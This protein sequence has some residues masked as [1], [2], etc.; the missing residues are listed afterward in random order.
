MDKVHPYEEPVKPP[1]LCAFKFNASHFAAT[2]DVY[3]LFISAIEHFGIF[4]YDDPGRARRIA[5]NPEDF[6][7]KVINRL[8]FY[9]FYNFHNFTIF[10][11]FSF[12][13]FH[14]LHS[15]F[16]FPLLYDLNVA[17]KLSSDLKKTL[18]FVDS[19][20][21]YKTGNEIIVIVLRRIHDEAFLS[22]AGNEPY[23]VTEVNEEAQ[24][25][26][27]EYFP[28]GTIDFIPI[29]PD[30]EEEEEEEDY[31]EEYDEEDYED[32]EEENDPNVPPSV[33]DL[34]MF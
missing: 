23:F 5:S 14:N 11:I 15:Q 34:S 31:Y 21:K 17:N 28:P 12:S 1:P 20:I 32:Y 4:E 10:T 9:Y 19:K 6:E 18:L 26:I 2:S 25:M 7:N 16:N 24:K 33:V 13:N 27:D 8:Q 30:A 22:F 29:D 3:K